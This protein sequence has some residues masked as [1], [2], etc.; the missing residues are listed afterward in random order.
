MDGAAH[1]RTLLAQLEPAVMKAI[2]SL[3]AQV[4]D[5]RLPLYVRRRTARTLARYQSAVKRYG[6][7]PDLSEKEEQA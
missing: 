6:L 3:E 2:A 7:L 5:E 4:L 1:A